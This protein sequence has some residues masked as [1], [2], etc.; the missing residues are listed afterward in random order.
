MPAYLAW[1]LVHTLL[2]TYWSNP[3]PGMPDP[4]TP[5][6]LREMDLQLKSVGDETVKY[7]KWKRKAE[8]HGFGQEI[9]PVG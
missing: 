3:S 9:I 4:A 7:G 5:E 2:R 6:A 8:L 1:V